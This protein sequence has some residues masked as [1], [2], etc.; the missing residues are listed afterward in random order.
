MIFTET[1]L[2]G[3]YIIDLSLRQDDRGFFARAFC[4]D[5]FKK[6]GLKYNMVQSNLSKSIHKNTLRG[7]HFQIDGAE[8]AK[9]IRCIRGA[10]T[11]VIIDIRP[12]SATYCEH[13]SV[14][15]TGDNYKMIY[16]PEGFAHGYLT[17][18]DNSEIFYQVSNF[19]TP[20][21]ERGIRW[22][23]PLFGINWGITDPII[24]EKDNSHPDFIKK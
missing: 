8:E 19:Y 12:E 9:L 6:M 2:K 14:E 16:V 24:S 1:K 13:I 21:S 17:N 22:N 20:G 15:L 3:A 5:E 7:M 18:E 23:D 4:A 11:D 10:I